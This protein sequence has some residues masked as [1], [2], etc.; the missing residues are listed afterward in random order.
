VISNVAGA[1]GVVEDD[2]KLDAQEGGGPRCEAQ[3]RGPGKPA[4][5]LNAM[6]NGL[7]SVTSGS[8][9]EDSAITP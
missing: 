2:Q 1:Y 3:L 9:S 4:E 5:R 8:A 7:A 6:F